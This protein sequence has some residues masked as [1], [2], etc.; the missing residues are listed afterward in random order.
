MKSSS[1]S[2]F[3]FLSSSSLS[4]LSSSSPSSSSFTFSFTFSFS[5]SFFFISFSFF[6]CSV[7]LSKL[8]SAKANEFSLEWES[9][10]NSCIIFLGFSSNNSSSPSLLLANIS[11]FLERFGFF[12]SV[13]FIICDF[14]FS[15]FISSSDIWIKSSFIF[16]S[17]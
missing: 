14:K 12:L 11:L 8:S 13:G 7:S 2:E 5:F 17:F 6:F 16:V 1:S 3:S 4:S 10:L 15:L 9:S